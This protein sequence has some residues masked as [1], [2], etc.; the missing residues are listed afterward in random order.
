MIKASQSNPEYFPTPEKDFMIV[1]LDL[2]SGL[3]EGLGSSIEPL[4]GKSNIMTLLFQCMQD[5]LHDVRQSSF[6][7]LGDLTKACFNHVK[8]CVGKYIYMFICVYM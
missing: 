2:L 7:L 8:P 1:A 6:A 4:V 5:P 3:S